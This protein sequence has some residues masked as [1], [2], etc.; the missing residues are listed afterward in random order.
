MRILGFYNRTWTEF[1]YLYI[2]E[3]GDWF[4]CQYGAMLVFVPLLL[5][6]RRRGSR[7]HIMCAASWVDAKVHERVRNSTCTALLTAQI[8]QYLPFPY[9]YQANWILANTRKC[10]N[11][12]TRIEKNQGCNHMTCRLC[13]HEFCWTCMGEMLRRLIFSC[14]LCIWL[15]ELLRKLVWSRTKHGWLL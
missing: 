5:S 10:P 11:C 3:S 15:H 6:L 9:N 13:K 4:W 8:H 2:C 12:N 7:A 1:V 14:L